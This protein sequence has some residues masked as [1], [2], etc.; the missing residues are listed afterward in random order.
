MEGWRI[1]WFEPWVGKIPEKGTAAHSSILAW[2][3]LWSE[4]PGRVQSMGLQKKSDTTEQLSRH[5]Q[6]DGTVTVT[7]RGGAF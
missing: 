4:K 6:R 2:R 7:S 1:S 5:T 3:N